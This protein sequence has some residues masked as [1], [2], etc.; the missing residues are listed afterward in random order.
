MCVMC[1]MVTFTIKKH[2]VEDTCT[3][4]K[5]LVREARLSFVSGHSSISFY[6]AIFLNI[7]IKKYVN[8]GI[9][10]YALQ[11]WNFI[12][13]LWISITRVNDYMHHSEDVLMGAIL[14]IICA[15]ITLF[16]IVK[17]SLINPKS[18]ISKYRVESTPV[19]DPQSGSVPGPHSAPSS[20][21][22]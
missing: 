7:F 14:G 16:K 20:N 12:L 5:Y 21:C 1:I 3:S 4:T 6:I 10:K 13:A 8:I 19:P 11:V 15:F 22:I 18:Q 17:Q 2:V 9:L